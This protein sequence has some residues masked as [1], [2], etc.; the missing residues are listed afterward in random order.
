[1]DKNTLIMTVALAVLLIVMLIPA[2]PQPV[3]LAVMAIAFLTIIWTRRGTFAFV[4]ANRNYMSKDPEK[5]KKAVESYK[6][7]VK[8]GGLPDNYTISAASVLIQNG[9]AEAGK[10]A[11]DTLAAK[12]G[13][14]P[15]V[16]ANAK[17]AASMAC[18]IKHDIDGAVK[19]I[20]DVRA[21]TYRD[22]NLY[23]NGATYYLEKRDVKAFSSLCSEWK[24]KSM[25][26]P[27]LKDLEAVDEMLKG[28]WRKAANIINELLSKGSCTFPDPYVHAAQ[29]KLHYHN[30]DEAVSYLREAVERSNFNAC[31]VI[32]ADTIEKLIT[33]LEDRNTALKVMNGNEEDPLSL[34]NGRIPALSD[35]SF[36]V[37]EEEEVKTEVKEEKKAHDDRTDADQELN[38]DDEAWLRA[39]G[40]S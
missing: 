22:K 15:A 30:A 7:A 3:K 17:I 38:D 20:E 9:E 2:V 21:T 5:R 25:N 10:A 8:M 26:T 1:M 6:K 18:W 32:T 28:N 39:H 23:I 33:M 4:S 13:K 36:E 40:L 37:D 31:S 27:A 11:L 12:S 29:V 35:R 14:K 19:Y 24:S 34:V 16:V